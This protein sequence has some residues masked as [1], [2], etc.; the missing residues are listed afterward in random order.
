MS[1][2]KMTNDLLHPKRE[3]RIVNVKPKTKRNRVKAAYKEYAIWGQIMSTWS[4]WGIKTIKAIII[5]PKSS[6]AILIILLAMKI[7]SNFYKY[8]KL[9]VFYSVTPYKA[10]FYLRF[11]LLFFNSKYS[12]KSIPIKSPNKYG[13]ALAHGFI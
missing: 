3:G 11:F 9:T 8:V 7:C 6:H 10:K 12:I 13:G 2:R 5:I 1:I 4:V